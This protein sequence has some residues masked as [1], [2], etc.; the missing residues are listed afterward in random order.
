[1]AKALTQEQFIEKA[2]IVH[3]GKY[4]YSDVVYINNRT[5][6]NIICPTHG[7]FAQLPSSHLLGNGCPQCARLWSDDHRKNLQK[8]SRASRGM[9]TQE[10]IERAM[11]VHGNKYDYSKV[12]Y[13]NQRTNVKIICPVHGLFEQKADSHLRGHGC[14]LCGL[15]SENHFGVHSWTEEQ[16]EKV[17]N[18]CIARYGADR[19][20]DSEEG[21]RKVAVVKSATA[22]REKMRDIISSDVVQT[23][24]KTTC[25]ERYGVTS[26]MKRQDILDKVFQ[27]KDENGTWN[28]S[29]PEMIVYDVLCNLFGE[30]DVVKQYRS[31]DYPFVCD[32]YIKSK[33]MYIELNITWTHGCHWYDAV[34]DES[35]LN[36]WQ[37]QAIDSD[38]YKNAISTWTKRDVN[39][40]KVAREN[41]LNYL[42]FW[43]QDLSDFYEWVDAGCSDG[44]DWDRMYSW[45]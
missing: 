1:M 42:V 7:V 44:K 36:K 24:T 30:T 10:W 18:T 11:A 12:V 33:Q 23:K 38:Y 22:F 31:I 28:T 41:N 20:L 13:V 32:F 37:Q 17:K 3:A 5:K 29:E 26:P 45:K 34:N 6:V 21:K 25:V 40:R 9:T 14:R 39:K 4:D 27:A 19:Y 15:Q 43:Q 35:V 8:A 16:R 2:N